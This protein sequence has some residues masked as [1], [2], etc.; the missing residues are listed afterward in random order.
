MCDELECDLS[1]AR[2]TGQIIKG[3]GGC[4]FHFDIITAD[5]SDLVL[6]FAGADGS[7]KNGPVQDSVK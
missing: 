6:N 3:P 7:Q 2:V 1:R 4:S 5:R